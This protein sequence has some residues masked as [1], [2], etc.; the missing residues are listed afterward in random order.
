MFTFR[1][2]A[3]LIVCLGGMA[4][5][6]CASDDSGVIAR[7]GG[8]EIME[9][10]VERAVASYGDKRADMK[11]LTIKLWLPSN[12]KE[13]SDSYLIRLLSL[14]PVID[15]RENVLSTEVRR[16]AMETL[17]HECVGS[18]SMSFH[19]MSGP[20]FSMVLDPPTHASRVIKAL[21]GKVHVTQ[22]EPRVLRFERLQALAGKRLRHPLLRKLRITP[23]VELRQDHT[24]VSLGA[25]PS[26]ARVMDWRVEKEGRPVPVETTSERRAGGR[27]EL[28]K[29]YL[30]P[31]PDACTLRL[32]V[33][34]PIEE[35][36]FVF[37]FRDVRLP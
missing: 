16:S 37:D 22:V 34:E 15:D 8:V 33:A 2:I 36:D 25:V 19:H 11:R 21:T 4:V 6:T 23:S 30:G 13:G 35:R 26:L 3:C 1:L 32:V 24:I 17:Q 28:L 20:V 18:E 27:V 9:L 31:L 10:R 29:T 14:N 12:W 5:T 7:S